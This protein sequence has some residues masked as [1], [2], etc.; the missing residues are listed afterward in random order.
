[1]VLIRGECSPLLLR[2]NHTLRQFVPVVQFAFP[3]SHPHPIWFCREAVNAWCRH[4]V[5]LEQLKPLVL[6]RLVFSE[7]K[8]YL[9]TYDHIE[10]DARLVACPAYSF[11]LRF[12]WRI[13]DLAIQEQSLMEYCTLIHHCLLLRWILHLTLPDASKGMSLSEIDHRFLKPWAVSPFCRISDVN[14]F[15]K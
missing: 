15:V 11:L 10:T 3:F 5:L 7:V 12:G 2:L 14:H 1:M 13:A 8:R 4:T 6:L 9:P